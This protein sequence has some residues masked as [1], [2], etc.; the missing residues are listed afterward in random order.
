M[1][2]YQFIT[3]KKGKTRLWRLF[4]SYIDSCGNIVWQYEKERRNYYIDSENN[5]KVY[6]EKN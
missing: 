5:E 3:N 2:E 6:I 1:Y 4:S